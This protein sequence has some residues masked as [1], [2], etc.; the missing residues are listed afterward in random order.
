MIPRRFS[1]ALALAG[2][3]TLFA[4]TAATAQGPC[5]GTEHAALDYLLGD[6]R[7]VDAAGTEVGR[8]SFRRAAGGC[9]VIE[10][11]RDP[12]DRE[13]NGLLYRDPASGLWHGT[14]VDPDGNLLRVSGAAAGGRAVLEGD[15]VSALGAARGRVTFERSGDDVAHKLELSVDGG[16]SWSVLAESRYVPAVAPAPPPTTPQ[17]STRTEPTPTRERARA[18]RSAGDARDSARPGAPAQPA[19]AAAPE[20]VRPA[21]PAPVPA[22]TPEA[23]RPPIEQSAREEDRP[24]PAPVTSAVE[25]LSAAATDPSPDPIRM[26]SP[27]RL[28]LPIGPVENLPEGYGWS[29]TDTAPYVT[30]NISISRVHVKQ[31]RR[32]GRTELEATIDL[33]SPSFLERID[34]GVEL[35]GPDGAV[36]IAEQFSK[37]AVGRG[38]PEQ[39]ASGAVSQTVR[40][41]LERE[42]F[43]ALFSGAGRPQLRMTVTVR[44]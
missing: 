9:A 18:R 31:L 27:M 20:P 16:A 14:W 30:E 39:S 12:R 22:P 10:A 1:A 24:A 35:L 23:P 26:A 32:G 19:P 7:L 17:P 6:W 21:D 29:S 8:S 25:V 33:Y 38:V 4:S 2:A 43:D 41:R 3:L 40:M 44:D 37:L 36:V 15:A 5:S 42:V 11:F 13:A 34:L 28:Q